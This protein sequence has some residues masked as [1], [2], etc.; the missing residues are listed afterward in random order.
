VELP[1]WGFEE[2]DSQAKGHSKESE[3][4]DEQPLN[5]SILSVLIKDHVPQKERY[6]SKL[7]FECIEIA[8]T[9]DKKNRIQNTNQ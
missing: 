8:S 3:F 9:E 6:S 1:D 4:D 5:Q 7:Q 2:E